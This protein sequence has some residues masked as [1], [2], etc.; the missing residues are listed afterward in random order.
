[1]PFVLSETVHFRTWSVARNLPA[2]KSADG[3]GFRSVWFLRD[4][5]HVRANDDLVLIGVIRK[6]NQLHCKL[7]MRRRIT[8]SLLRRTAEELGLCDGHWLEEQCHACP[9]CRYRVKVVSTHIWD[10]GVHNGPPPERVR[11]GF[12]G[13]DSCGDAI[14]G[15]TILFE[16][17]RR[18]SP[19]IWGLDAA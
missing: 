12:R 1:M 2:V 7:G 16:L 4:A 9:P 17:E 8:Y 14:G 18:P 5:N 11:R 15:W 13:L 3:Y 10:S 19:G 6:G